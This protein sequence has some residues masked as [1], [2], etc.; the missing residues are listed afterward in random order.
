MVGKRLIPSIQPFTTRPF[1]VNRQTILASINH[2]LRDSLAET[3]EVRP[4][5][6]IVPS[7]AQDIRRGINVDASAAAT[8]VIP[9]EQVAAFV[10]G[11]LS[12]DEVRNVCEAALTDNSVLAELIAAVRSHQQAGDQLPPLSDALSAQLI[13]MRSELPAPPDHS[14]SSIILPE[15]ETL[16]PAGAD[17]VTPPLEV[18][19]AT[20]S[21][22]RPPRRVH[23]RRNPMITAAAVIALAATIL[24]IIFVVTSRNQDRMPHG[25]ELVENDTAPQGPD[26]PDTITTDDPPQPAIEQGSD[27]QQPSMMA[28]ESQPQQ[29][30]ET[31]DVVPAP[32]EDLPQ[33]DAVVRDDTTTDQKPPSIEEI[34]KLDNAIP[35]T[36][37][38]K[39]PPRLAAMRWTEISGL[40]A[41][42]T[43]DPDSTSVRPSWQSVHE[44]SAKLDPSGGTVSLRTMPLSR[45]QAELPEG[46]KIVLAADSG[47]LVT[48][49]GSR[50]SVII[51]LHHGSIAIADLPDGTVI[52]IQGGDKMI[53]SLKW[54]E[55]AAVVLNRA[56]GGLQVHI[57]R[58]TI[59]VNNQPRQAESINVSD[60]RSVQTIDKP[61]RLPNW[62]DRPVDSIGI[63]RTILAQIAETDNVSRTLNQ[64][65]TEM[66]AMPQLSA[67]DKRTLATLAHWH[68]AMA[69]PNLFRLASSRIPAMRLAA[70]R[71]L[72][73]MP[74]SDPRYMRTWI[75]IDRAVPNK[76]RVAQIRRWCEMARAGLKPNRAQTEQMI[77]GLSA[78]D[79]AGRAM[80]DFMLRQFYGNLV[81]Q[82]D[83]TWTGTRQ[84]RVINLWRQ[85]VGLPPSR[86]A[87]GAAALSPNANN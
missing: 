39:P 30:P 7:V 38:S 24:G 86:N 13:A 68:A 25:E 63:P 29:T 72:V 84:Q 11:H 70:M 28:V 31:I 2:H 36:P 19:S 49:G 44:K 69:G 6:E 43:L 82:Y 51:D 77:A 15:N 56:T 81:P 41:Q 80:A 59:A 26:S 57:N 74:K 22:G 46:G 53:A 64:R 67:G 55:K 10:D 14:D 37:G 65:I 71:R 3:G 61:K 66:A 47:I 87:A 54:T 34:P 12:A 50:A 42:Q 52:A 45:A 85:K 4:L 40:L 33:S 83:P 17:T 27:D 73:S 60:N 76:Q 18:V 32:S 21:N 75:T 48:A 8:R 5:G 79:V 1:F 23:L 20:S 9:I 35:D 62:V 78:Q 16:Q 58:G